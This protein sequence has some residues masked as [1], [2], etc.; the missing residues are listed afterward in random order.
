MT[1]RGTGFRDGLTIDFGDGVAVDSLS[2]VDMFEVKVYITI[3][4]DAELGPRDIT[5]TNPDNKVG[6]GA[7]LYFIV[8]TDPST[9][10]IWFLDD[11]TDTLNRFSISE[12]AIVASY[13]T[14]PAGAS[15]QGLVFDGTN[16]WIIAAGSDDQVA[17]ID[18]T[19]GVVTVLDVFEAPLNGTGTARDAAYDSTDFWIPNDGTDSIYRVAVDGG[20]VLETI[21][22]PDIEPRGT[23]WA[24]G[25]LYCNDKG[26]DLV[27]VWDPDAAAWSEVFSVPIPPDGPDS[28]PF[29]T[30]MAWDGI[31][32]WLCNSSYE[33]DYI[34][35]V[36]PDG[37][38]LNAIVMP[39]RGDSQPTGVV[40]TQK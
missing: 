39:N 13:D 1:V 25:K 28:N 17:K 3:A 27:Y 22:S 35:Q 36:S 2:Y 29:P 37:T 7:D 26:T 5:V 30:G 14:T 4:A 20:E 6:V 10:F 11:G 38:L 18:T 23:T 34:Y 24:D 33:F 32:F 12:Q 15:L 31:S 19:G 16:L 40:F 8:D 21:P 9:G